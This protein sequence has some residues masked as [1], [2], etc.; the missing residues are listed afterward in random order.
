MKPIVKGPF[1]KWKRAGWAL[2]LRGCDQ[3]TPHLTAPPSQRHAWWHISLRDEQFFSNLLVNISRPPVVLS[4]SCARPVQLG[5]LPSQSLY[6]ECC[7]N[8]W[9]NSVIFINCSLEHISSFRK[10]TEQVSRCEP[11]SQ[12]LQPMADALGICSPLG[13]HFKLCKDIQSNWMWVLYVTG[14]HKGY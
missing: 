14:T 2:K 1:W 8:L 4:G 11:V 6:I 12:P 7:H 5:T 9:H 3:N 13:W 10:A